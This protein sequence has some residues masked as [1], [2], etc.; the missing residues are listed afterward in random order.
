MEEVLD[1]EKKLIK[2]HPYNL[3][4]LIQVGEEKTEKIILGDGNSRISYQTLQKEKVLK[5]IL[6]YTRYPQLKEKVPTDAIHR[7]GKSGLLG[8]P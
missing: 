6:T 4:K 7:M 8:K 1:W 3:K 2:E 5:Q